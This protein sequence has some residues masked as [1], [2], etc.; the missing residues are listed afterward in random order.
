MNVLLITDNYCLEE[1]NG[2]Y[3]HR[4]LDDHIKAY[5][6]LGEICLCTPMRH[7]VS[8]NRQIDLSSARHREIEKENT[9]YRRFI[10]R[11]PNNEII[12]EE[13]RKAD[14]VVGFVPSSVCDTAQRHAEKYGKTFLSIVI[15][16]AWDILWHHSIK[17]RF[18]A[19]FSHFCT[20]RT[21]RNSDYV[22]YVTDKY[23]QKKYPTNGTGIGISDVVIHDYDPSIPAKRA[24]GI[25]RKTDLK[26]LSLMTIGAIDVRYKAQDDVIRAMAALSEEG[27][28]TEYFLVGGGSSER[29][30]KTAQKYGMEPYVHFM[31]ACPHEDIFRL[32][33]QT[34]IYIQPS[35][36]E[37]LPRAVI[38][39]MSRAVPVICSDAGGMPELVSE[40]CIYR[41]GDIQGLAASIRRLAATAE[42]LISHSE[43]NHR[44]A[45]AFT[46]GTLQ[47][48]RDSFL[49][50]ILSNI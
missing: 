8:I 9:V 25:R 23:L 43:A 24:E 13:V 15:A 6:A 37:G 17:G 33:D 18:M 41:S 27:Y 48:R 20:K 26:K 39:A 42:S 1:V 49:A 45:K 10:C 29:L 21:I 2:I 40:E 11:R 31:G 32:L 19:P 46:S 30:K 28:K 44:K 47:K 38:E 50:N 35:H 12:E 36:T 5:K 34:D 16:S 3:Y 4:C 22:I 14:I 7:T